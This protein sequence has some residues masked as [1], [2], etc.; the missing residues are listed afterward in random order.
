VESGVDL[1]IVDVRSTAAFQR[2][3]IRGAV[4]MPMAELAERYAE[5]PRDKT[6]VTYCA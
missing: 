5:L 2:A 1:L 4:S 3:H 6:I